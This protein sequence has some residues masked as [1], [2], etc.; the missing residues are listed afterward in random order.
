MPRRS[1]L[2][3]IVALLIFAPAA[4]A[5]PF[6][7][8]VIFGDSLSDVGNIDQASFG[9]F[10]GGDYYDGRFSNGP[11][12]VDVLNAQLGLAPLNHSRDGGYNYAHGGAETGGG[13]QSFG[14]IRNMGRQVDDYL[15]SRTPSST[16][17]FILWGGGNDFDN[18]QTN[19]GV[20]VNNMSSHITDLANAGAEHF[21][22]LNLPPLDLTPKH[23]KTGSYFTIGQA[24]RSYNAQLHS[25]LLALESSL[26]VD[27]TEFDIYDLFDTM[28]ADPGAYGATNWWD[29]AYNESNGNVVP[30][31]DEYLFWDGLHP[32]R[33]AHNIIGTEAHALLMPVTINP[34]PAT[35]ML[36]LL[37]GG[38]VMIKRRRR[39]AA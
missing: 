26:S 9:I 29:P 24:T 7:R 21:L 38:A 23:H 36:L 3:S 22:V 13:T 34:E 19:A 4:G 12:W 35:A 17:L 28:L 25:Q 27:I 15:G 33:V 10:P 31:P 14:I 8:L 30:N 20:P 32:T 5:Y 18:G 2:I 6:T 11:L 1:W 16:E 39:V 37:T